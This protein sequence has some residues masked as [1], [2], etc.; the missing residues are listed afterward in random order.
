MEYYESINLQSASKI[1]L[2]QSK[3]IFY[4]TIF[5]HVLPQTEHACPIYFSFEIN[6]TARVTSKWHSTPGIGR[7]FTIRCT[8]R[9]CYACLPTGPNGELDLMDPPT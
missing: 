6:R 4:R 7:F 3:S 5:G 8:V 9:S 2:I 1:Q